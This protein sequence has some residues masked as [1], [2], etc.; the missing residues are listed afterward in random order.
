VAVGGGLGPGSSG[1]DLLSSDART[2]HS[3]VPRSDRSRVF[4]PLISRV[5]S[6]ASR[7]PTS[8]LALA[9]HAFR[10]NAR[11]LGSDFARTLVLASL[12]P[13]LS[14][15]WLSE[16]AGLKPSLCSLVRG[17]G[18]RSDPARSSAASLGP[19]SFVGGFARTNLTRSLAVA[20]GSL[21]A[22]ASHAAPLIS[23]ARR[24]SLCSLVLS[25]LGPK[26]REHAFL[27]REHA[28]SLASLPPSFGPVNYSGVS[29]CFV[30]SIS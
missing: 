30:V 26:E 11:P 17:G 12:G 10:R 16:G 21:A 18:V 27:A 8:P 3:L 25:A 5:P 20:G 22:L 13:S 9:S 24:P 19:G 2:F 29:R 23:R 15:A 7:V 28:L 4:S 14:L 6:L 1:S